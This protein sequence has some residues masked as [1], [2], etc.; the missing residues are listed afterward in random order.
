MN[1]QAFDDCTTH[2]DKKRLLL[3]SAINILVRDCQWFSVFGDFYNSTDK[4]ATMAS[5]TANPGASAPEHFAS[6]SEQEEKELR[7]VFEIL[8]DYATKAPLIREKDNL[9]RWLS[10]NRSRAH[11][12]SEDMAAESNRRLEEI[13]RELKKF[14]AIPYNDKRR[15]IS[16]ADVTEKIQELKMVRPRRREAE[17]MDSSAENRQKK[18]SRREVEE[19]VWEVDENLDGYLDWQEFK[20]MFNRNITDRTGLEP[21]RMVSRCDTYLCLT[22]WF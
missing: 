19:L 13:Q 17:D 14:E 21:S 16:V 9:E 2:C 5:T 22:S 7:R 18:V 3:E 15:K 4:Q 20:L 6:I 1:R 12:A 10:E 11:T 8:T